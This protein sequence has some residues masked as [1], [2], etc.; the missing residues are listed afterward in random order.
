[1]L[2]VK[3]SQLEIKAFDVMD[4]GIPLVTVRELWPTIFTTGTIVVRTTT[5]ATLLPQA[6]RKLHRVTV[7]VYEEPA[8][9]RL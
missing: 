8:V 4:N 5:V 3:P 6:P 1:M 7:K 9:R 2:D